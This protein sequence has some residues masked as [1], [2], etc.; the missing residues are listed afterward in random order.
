MSSKSGGGSSASGPLEGSGTST[1]RLICCFP[2]STQL[3]SSALTALLPPMLM[4]VALNGKTLQQATTVKK[5]SFSHSPLCPRHCSRSRERVLSIHMEW[6]LQ[7]S[8]Q[9]ALAQEAC[10]GVLNGVD[11]LF[12][13]RPRERVQPRHACMHAWPRPSSA[14]WCSLHHTTTAHL[15]LLSD[16]LYAL[17][18]CL[19]SRSSPTA[20]ISCNDIVS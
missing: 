1:V 20:S 10:V 18:S 17:T 14:Q 12:C 2:T 3:P 13:L 9:K 5:L 7:P 11:T 19:S 6:L 15:A 8:C 4:P 16:P